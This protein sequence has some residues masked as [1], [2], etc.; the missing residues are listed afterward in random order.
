MV[1]KIEGKVALITGGAS[2]LGL[3]HARELLRN[4]LKGVTLADID[5]KNGEQAQ[6]EISAEF[7]NNKVI[8]VETDVSHKDQ[9]EDAFEKTVEYFGNLDILINNAGIFND[10]IWE[11]EV[12]INLN[13]TI[14][15]TFLGM[16]KYLKNYKQG[17]E[18]VIVNTSSIAGLRG[19]NAFPVY[20]GTKFA[21][22]GTTSSWGN[23][24]HYERTRVR[25]VSICPGVTATSILETRNCAYSKDYVGAWT[26]SIDDAIEDKNLCQ[27]SSFERACPYFEIC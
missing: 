18:A 8:F 2:G 24:Y 12:S 4:G 20:A 15:G 11:R 10:S 22:M 13:G 16:E 27:T 7:G 21:I 19:N 14:H 25:V 26:Y 6:K 3:S 5:V 9:F 1:F 23:S 17:E